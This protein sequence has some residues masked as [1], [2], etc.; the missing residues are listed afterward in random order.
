MIAKVWEYKA[1]S[2]Q[3]NK[4]FTWPSVEASGLSSISK[5]RERLLVEKEIG[6]GF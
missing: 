4:I 6:K 5:G 3:N 1:N 2:K